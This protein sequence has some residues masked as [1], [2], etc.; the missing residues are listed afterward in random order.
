MTI[1][2]L[3]AA[4]LTHFSMTYATDKGNLIY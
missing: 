2:A 1:T 4:I 3:I